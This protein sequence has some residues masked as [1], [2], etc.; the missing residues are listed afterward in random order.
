MTRYALAFFDVDSTLVTIEGIDLLA[1]KD[2]RIAELTEAAM[3]GQVPLEDVYA[4]RLSLVRPS[5]RTVERLARSYLD[6]ITPGA[7]LVI[8]E[9]RSQ[10][11]D[12]QL[13][14]AGIEQA[15][16]PLAERFGLERR[17]VHAVPLLFDA[18]GHYKDFDRRSPLTRARG[19]ETVVLD[20]RARSHGRAVFIGDGVSDLETRS[21]VD[22]FV[23]FGGVR[24]RERVQQEADV[25]IDDLRQLLPIV[26]E[27]ETNLK[28]LRRKR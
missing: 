18:R 16:L 24:K 19:K 11:I 27:G 1:G 15:I 21:A 20:S 13:V 2:A 28:R 7:E 6:N 4:R 9:L 8:S 23:G 26:L 5:R 22:L 12:V 14:T 25:F 10:G 17:A 3:S